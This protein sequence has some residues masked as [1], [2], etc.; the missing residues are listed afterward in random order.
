MSAHLT[1]EFDHSSQE[2]PAYQEAPRFAGPLDQTGVV[3]C[4]DVH[5]VD[6]VDVVT[7]PRPAAV[8]VAWALDKLWVSGVTWAMRLVYL[9]WLVS[10][11][12]VAVFAAR[13][14]GHPMMWILPVMGS[15]I[16]VLIAAVALLADSGWAII[17]ICACTYATGVI[18]A[19]AGPVYLGVAAQREPVVVEKV[20][21]RPS[22]NGCRDYAALS[23][24]TGQDL[25]WVGCALDGTP[26]GLAPGGRTHVYVDPRGWS[27]PQLAV[28]TEPLPTQLGLVIAGVV[29]F[30]TC[31]AASGRLANAD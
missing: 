26:T 30:L 23:D 22:R 8:L 13:G 18:L 3:G 19:G 6:W 7:W 28:C 10:T 16:V 11:L 31:I 17:A 5:H 1:M 15:A 27:D 12:V 24:A 9:V 29:V 21:C 2:A 25:A 20:E 4:I 14:F